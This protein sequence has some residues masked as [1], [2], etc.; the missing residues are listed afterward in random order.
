MPSP[1]LRKVSDERDSQEKAEKSQGDALVT[2]TSLEGGDGEWQFTAEEINNYEVDPEMNRRILRKLDTRILVL[3]FFMYLFSALDRG[4]LGNA[5]TDG[6]TKQLH[7]VGNQY[8][9]MLTVF[10]IPFC[11]MTIPGALLTKRFGPHRMLPLYMMGWGAMA[12]LNA[13]CKNYGGVVAVR[14]ILGVFEG[15]FGPS[16]AVFLSLYYT[17]AEMGK[18]M[19]AW[20]SS[21]AISGYY[22]LF[23]IRSRLHGWQIL[24]LLEGGLTLLTAF[25]STFVLPPHPTRCSFLTKEEKKAAVMRLLKDASHRV[26]APWDWKEIMAPLK[27]WKFYVWMVYALCYGTASSTAGTFLPQILGRFHYSTVKTNL[28]TVAPNIVS[29]VTLW[30]TV[31]SSD[32]FRERSIHLMTANALTFAGCLGLACL[33]VSSD[34]A[35]YAMCFLISMGAFTPTCLFHTWHN[36]NDPNENGRAFRT[37]VMTFAANAGGIVSSNIFLQ[38]DA[39]KYTRALIVSAAMEGCGICILICLRTYMWF[40]NRRR[41][42]AQGVIWTTKDVPTAVLFEGPKNPSFRHFL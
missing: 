5:V 28:Y 8:N 11:I 32:F 40:D 14:M 13:A 10:Y 4:N 3:I 33:P 23:Q 35:G 25:I 21:S 1:S 18:R 15:L 42:R 38:S 19:A 22:G 16:L 34:H 17:R 2:I 41:N 36:N 30:I 9:I 29:A 27:E 6:M 31:L 12:M 20:Y 37:G 7:F 26:N 24:F 39:P